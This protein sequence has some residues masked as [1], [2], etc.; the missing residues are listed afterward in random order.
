MKTTLLAALVLALSGCVHVDRFVGPHGENMA[1]IKCGGYARMSDCY[2]KAREVCG[3]NF[4]LAGKREG[5]VYSQNSYNH[6][7]TPVSTRSITVICDG[8]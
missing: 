2:S 8:E 3:G 7:I 6:T 4:E 1:E 5:V